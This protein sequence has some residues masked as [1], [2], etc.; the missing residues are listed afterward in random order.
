MANGDL[1]LAERCRARAKAQIETAMRILRGYA[2][3][4]QVRLMPK[5]IDLHHRLTLVT[6]DMVDT[7]RLANYILKNADT[8]ATA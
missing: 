5:V 3:A 8:V 1:E 2:L 7:Y 4:T 6:L